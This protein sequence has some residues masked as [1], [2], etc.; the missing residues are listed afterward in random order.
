VGGG[1]RRRIDPGTSPTGIA[2][3]A[4][5]L[6]LPNAYA[7]TVTRLDPTG[8]RTSIPVGRSP[9]AVAFGLG[10][11]WVVDALDDMLVRIDP[12][13]Q[14]VVDTFPVGRFPD[15]VAVG[16]GSVWVANAR[17]GTVSR[18][19]PA[20]RKVETIRVGGSPQSLAV[21]DGRVWVTV[22]AALP[23]APAAG[24]VARLESLAD[25]E[26]MDPAT[27][28]D[29][30]AWQLLDATCA[31]LLNYPDRP[32]PAGSQLEPEVAAAM[33]QVSSDGR[34]YTFAIRPG[35]RF[36]SGERVTART[37]A[38]SIERSLGKA[39][40]GPGRSYL[41][42]VVG[43]RAFMAGRAAHVSGIEAR[44]S[45][46]TIRLVQ[47]QPDLPTRL[48]LPFFCAVP[49]GTPLDPPSPRTI[50]GAGPYYV[51][52]YTPGQGVVLE[53]NP[54]YR[55]SRPHRLRRI[56]F[57]PGVA[58][59]QQMRDV[60]SGNADY[61]FDVPVADDGEPG[62]TRNAF[63]Q[64]DMLVLN[65]HR[66]LF[67]D[68][69]L[70][71]A[72]NFAIDR[73]AL[74]ALGD[75]WSQIPGRTT[76]QYL[77]P[78]MPGF[79]DVRVY[80]S[81]PDLAR[82]RQLAAGRTGTAV[83]YTCDQPPCDRIAQIVRTDLGRIGIDVVVKAFG[84]E[85]L[86]TRMARK[87]EPFD[88]GWAGWVSDYPDPDDTLDVLLASGQVPSF[89]DPAWRARL[90]RAGRLSG[91][92]RFL[93]YGRLDGELAR[94]AAPWVAYANRPTVAFLSARIGCRVYQPVY[95]IDL[96]ALCVRHRG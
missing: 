69:R 62:L 5:A 65:T 64:L 58:P 96:A 63:P 67:A 89:D 28:Y 66:P 43:A 51:A 81:H 70:R 31:K 71:Q 88:L 45:T 85:E 80:P 3:G 26:G 42:D 8:L 84:I 11:L 7:D 53:R 12:A 59:Q 72:V 4:G 86:F 57:T 79:H 19:D 17:D 91:P 54:Y 75:P 20:T 92:E 23:Q 74:A 21:A 82:A 60:R 37:F 93:A 95:G 10:S 52:A 15:G 6:W 39:L 40:D 94:D 34:T 32:A 76:D 16:L 30:R 68:V 55:G 49:I 1:A 77:P 24:G 83:M 61:A 90:A 46:L 18:V 48:A 25:V 27:V 73:T 22:D 13:T 35:F 41:G 56:V 44:G 2:A 14:A 47:P 38:Y 36:S 78:V 33:P 50:P 87:G 9:A 29:P